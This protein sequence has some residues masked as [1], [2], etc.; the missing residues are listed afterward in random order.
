MSNE[1]EPNTKRSVRDRVFGA[2]ANLDPD[3]Q[4]KTD[5]FAK[6]AIRTGDFVEKHVRKFHENGKAKATAEIDKTKIKIFG[7]PKKKKT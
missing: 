4:R 5:G 6:L 3:T 2:Y 1:K 7:K